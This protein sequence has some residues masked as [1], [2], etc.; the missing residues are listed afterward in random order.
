[1][2]KLGLYIH[3]PFCRQKCEYCDFYSGNEYKD[4][5]KYINALMLHMEDYSPVVSD[6]ETDTIFIG[7]G[8]P[9]CV[10]VKYIL[11]LIDGIY[12][13]FKVPLSA[14]F[15]IEAN[16]A[17]VNFTGLKRYLQAGINRLSLGCQSSF[18]NELAALGRIHDYDAFEQT[19][20]AA[21]DAG[22]EIINVDLMYGIPEQTKDSFMKTLERICELNPEHISVYGLKVEDNTPF[23]QKAARGELILPG[24]DEEFEMYSSAIKYLKTMG[25]SQYEISNFAKPGYE[26]RH[27]LKYWNMGEY[28]GLGP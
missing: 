18:D 16:P 4:Y 14:E 28:L 12:S 3:M 21:R 17:T 27:N 5:K 22:F 1:M 13:Y 6:Y 23:G 2:K 15:T 7:G 10:P 9:S 11:E 26:C 24:E 8:T 25:Y 19:F 20:I